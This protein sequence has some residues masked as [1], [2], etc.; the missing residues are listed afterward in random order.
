MFKFLI[1]MK[2]NEKF[3]W[4]WVSIIEMAYS[5]VQKN[6]SKMGYICVL[7]CFNVLES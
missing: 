6:G 4:L 1:D 2:I 5:L 7:I 3:D